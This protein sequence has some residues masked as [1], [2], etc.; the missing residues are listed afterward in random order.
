MPEKLKELAQKLK[1]Q[2]R[3]VE[4]A[5]LELREFIKTPTD[6][7]SIEALNGRY[8][9]ELREYRRLLCEYNLE[10]RLFEKKRLGQKTLPNK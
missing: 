5:R 3:Q 1:Y 9:M 6:T 7:V 8:D 4:F 2:F 10:F